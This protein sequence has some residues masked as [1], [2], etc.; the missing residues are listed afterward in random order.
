M[1]SIR[2][3]F[4]RR[5]GLVLSCVSNSFLFKGNHLNGEHLR[6]YSV[7]KTLHEDK[8]KKEIISYIENDRKETLA[9][10]AIVGKSTEI[11]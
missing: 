11:T 3:I 7:L 8:S 10:K 2:R 6:T 9:Y 5:N 4:Y 1:F